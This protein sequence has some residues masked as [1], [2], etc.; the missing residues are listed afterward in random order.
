[1]VF[2]GSRYLW[3]TL[4]VS[5]GYVIF[6]RVA[7]CVELGQSKHSSLCSCMHNVRLYMVVVRNG[8]PASTGEHSVTGRF[9]VAGYVVLH[10]HAHCLAQMHAPGTAAVV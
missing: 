9:A 2:A 7:V 4:E 1:M 8:S 10:H 3:H 5:W 6:C